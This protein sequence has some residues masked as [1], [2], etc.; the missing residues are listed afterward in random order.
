MSRVYQSLAQL[1]NV[2]FY[3]IFFS[4][5]ERVTYY[6][7]KFLCQK[8]NNNNKKHIMPRRIFPYSVS[9]VFCIRSHFCNSSFVPWIIP[10]ENTIIKYRRILGQSKKFVMVN[11]ISVS[12]P[13]S[14]KVNSYHFG[15][16]DDDRFILY[17][18]T[19]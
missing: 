16:E 6:L 12:F 11:L 4:C 14:L 13:I 1:T 8:K 3:F 2:L 15:D 17:S 7:N 19:V 10:C 5:V 18:I 9:G